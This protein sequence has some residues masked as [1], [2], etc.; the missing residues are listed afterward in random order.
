MVKVHYTEKL[1]NGEVL[2]LH[3]KNMPIE[4]V[5]GSEELLKDG[6]KVYL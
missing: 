1:L 5:L 3:T 6:M 4:F 2:I